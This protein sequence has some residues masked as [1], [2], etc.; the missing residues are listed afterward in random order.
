M[1]LPEGLGK[2]EGFV[3]GALVLSALATI[4]LVIGCVDGATWQTTVIGI[5]GSVVGG[6]ALAAYRK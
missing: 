2:S 1:S 6:G 4:L 3:A 5:W